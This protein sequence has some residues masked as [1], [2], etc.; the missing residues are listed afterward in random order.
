MASC[1]D[2]LDFGRFRPY[3]NDIFLTYGNGF[4]STFL[5]CWSSL[6]VP[7]TRFDSSPPGQDTNLNSSQSRGGVGNVDESAEQ[8]RIGREQGADRHERSDT[9]DETRR[10][11]HV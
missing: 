5:T 2:S 4:I 11:L 9:L 1:R 7:E 8:T 6:T 10:R 3:R